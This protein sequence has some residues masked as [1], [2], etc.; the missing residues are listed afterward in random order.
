[1]AIP[2]ANDWNENSAPEAL[3]FLLPKTFPGIFI[4]GLN[5]NIYSLS[6]LNFPKFTAVKFSASAIFSIC[7][8]FVTFIWVFVIFFYCK[9]IAY[10]GVKQ[11][12]TLSLFSYIF[13]AFAENQIVTNE[14]FLQKKFIQ[15]S[16][17][18][19]YNMLNF[20]LVKN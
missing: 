8:I 14:L 1:M 19:Q 10:V 17:I 20:V 4:S 7:F 5:S 11:E 16:L 18:V 2:G 9:D 6:S 3:R 15:Y 13:L 12:V